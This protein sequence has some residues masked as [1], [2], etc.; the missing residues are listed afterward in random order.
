MALISLRTQVYK[1]CACGECHWNANLDLSYIVHLNLSFYHVLKWLS[2]QSPL[3]VHCDVGLLGTCQRLAVLPER[4]EAAPTM[5]KEKIQLSPWKQDLPKVD[6]AF[7]QIGNTINKS[8]YIINYN[9]YSI[10]ASPS[11]QIL[12]YHDSL[13]VTL[14]VS[15]NSVAVTIWFFRNREVWAWRDDTLQIIA[16][17][18]N[19]R[20]SDLAHETSETVR[21]PREVVATSKSQ[22]CQ[23]MT[24]CSRFFHQTLFPLTTHDS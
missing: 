6:A 21:V 2:P 15:F 22:N 4:F 16:P 14:H 5:A 1:D 12:K 17:W 20:P 9:K 24:F 23:L 11:E 13:L 19:L 3:S 18:R 10:F 8:I 7:L